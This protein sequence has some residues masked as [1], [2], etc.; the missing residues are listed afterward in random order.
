MKIFFVTDIHGSDICWRKF[1]NAGPFYGADVAVVGGDLTGK[2]MVPVVARGARFETNLQGHHVIL[3][4]DEEMRAAEQQIRNRGYYP[5]RVSQEE[6]RH[7]QEDPE[8]V[9]K[10]FKEAMIGSTPSARSPSGRRS[11]RCSRSCHS[12]ATSTRARA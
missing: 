12:T 3:Q 9:D 6:Y 8:I 11:S 10:R 5:L 1:L 4:T 2:A 7:M